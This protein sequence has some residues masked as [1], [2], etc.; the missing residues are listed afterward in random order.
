[1]LDARCRKGPHRERRRTCGGKSTFAG[2][3]AVAVGNAFFDFPFG[4]FDA[5]LHFLAGLFQLLLDFAAGFAGLLLGAEFI[6]FRAAAEHRGR[7]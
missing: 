1:M 5:L 3:L 7:Q 6:G 4:R 2:G